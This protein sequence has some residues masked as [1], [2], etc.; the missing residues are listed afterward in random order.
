MTTPGRIKLAWPSAGRDEFARSR[1]LCWRSGPLASPAGPERWRGR[2]G[3]AL[4]RRRRP[5]A[6]VGQEHPRAPGAQCSGPHACAVADVVGREEWENRAGWAGAYRELVD[7][8]DPADATG[9]ATPA[10]LP[11]KHALWRAAPPPL[12]PPAPRAVADALAEGRPR[13][14]V[15]A[16]DR[17][18]DWAPAR[19]VTKI[20]S[21]TCVTSSTIRPMG[22]RD[23]TRRLAG[24]ALIPFEKQRQATRRLHRD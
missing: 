21:S 16:S 5:V 14:R 3:F 8:D 19:A 4:A 10:G 7:H 17:E 22:M 12:G 15:R 20:V 1:C 23:E 9:P 6:Q 13:R 2:A 24:I 18:Q 11:D